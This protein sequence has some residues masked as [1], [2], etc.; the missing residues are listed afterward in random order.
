MARFDW[1]ARRFIPVQSFSRARPDLPPKTGEV[2]ELCWG[3]RADF[4]HVVDDAA[5]RDTGPEIILKDQ[6]E[7]P[8]YARILHAGATVTSQIVR[9]EGENDSQWVKV[10]RFERM[11]FEFRE[12]I[13]KSRFS[14]SQ[15]Y[16]LVKFYLRFNLDPPEEEEEGEEETTGG[17]A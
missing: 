14:E 16:R 8:V 4:S 3:K 2:N 13:P 11:A 17:D 1:I 5:K 15:R 6:A 9:I 12:P 7:T 10:R